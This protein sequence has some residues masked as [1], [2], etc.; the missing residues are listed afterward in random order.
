MARKAD[1]QSAVHARGFSDIIGITLMALALLLLVAQ[2]TFHPHDVAANRVPPNETIH[3]WIGAF[4]A[5]A[6]NGFFQL[7]GA[8][9]FVLPILMVLFGVG[10]LFEFFSYLK[11]RWPWAVVAFIC[12]IGFLDLYTNRGLLDKLATNPR[13]AEGAFLEKMTLNINAPSAGGH[14]GSALNQLLFGYFGTVGAT[15]VFVTLYLMSIIYLTNFHVNQWLRGIWAREPSPKEEKDWSPEEKAL[16]R[17]AKELEKQA[18]KLQEQ[19]EKAD[20]AAAEKLGLGADLK[21]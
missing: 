15:I 21:P 11:R 10:Y 19:A 17:R 3:N 2:L 8:G 4:G 14:V 5:W 12:C 9:A 16:A 13:L 7:F 18:R 1:S 6:A 20:A